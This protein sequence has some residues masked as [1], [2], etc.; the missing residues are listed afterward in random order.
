[1]SHLPAR[2][3]TIVELMIVIVVI[4]ILAAIS[5]VAYT[6]VQGRAHDTAIQNDLRNLGMLIMEYQAFN[7]RLPA[8]AEVDVVAESFTP[9]VNSYELDVSPRNNLYY[10][11][12]G[13]EAWGLIALSRSG[14]MFEYMHD[15]GLARHHDQDVRLHSE[16]ACPS[17]LGER[18]GWR[19]FH[20]GS[21]GWH[22][23]LGI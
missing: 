20:H 23:S 12:I 13:D 19:A 10:C 22:S 5:I 17:L 1:M 9:S 16:T 21:N 7:S 14:T 2:R 4:A 6:G 15:S 8:G 3:L 11:R 18:D